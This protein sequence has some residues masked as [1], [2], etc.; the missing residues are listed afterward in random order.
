[1]RHGEVHNPEKLLYGKLPG[2]RLS[3]LGQQMAKAVATAL[4]DHD[5]T[6]VIA[7]P[8]ERAQETALP[9]AEQFG[10]PVLTDPKLIE[11]ANRFEG[12]QVQRALR[13]PRYW[14][15]MWNPF[16]PSW[17]EPY[18]RILTRMLAALASARVAA[19]GHEAVCVSHQL[20]I[21]T[22]RRALEGRRLWHDPRGRQ[23][24]LASLTSFH[25]DDEMLTNIT[26]SEPA[27]HLGPGTGRGA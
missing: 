25:F 4:T 27:A 15:I 1:M 22:L 6:T 9:I 17:G 2:Y 16:R 24:H 21:W 3:L 12:T 26:Y 20:P 11:S 7:S 8:L 14:M 13:D 5:I 23:C 19:A 18:A 10:L